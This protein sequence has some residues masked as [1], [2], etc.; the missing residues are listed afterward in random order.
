[1]AGSFLN[2]QYH[3]VRPARAEKLPDGRKR[4]TR[5]VSFK[6]NSEFPAEMGGTVAT[7]TDAASNWSSPPSGWSDLYLISAQTDTSLSPNGSGNNP[8]TILTYETAGTIAQTDETRNNG[9]LL[10]RTIRT[11]HTAPST[12]SGYTL[13]S[14]VDDN[15][16]WFDTFTY[17]FAKGTGQ[18]S[19]SDETKNNGALLLTTIR[20]ITVPGVL[21]TKGA[22]PISTPAGYTLVS[23]DYSEQDGH[24]VWV[25][26]YAKGVG[27]IG[28]TIDYRQ[29][30]DAG[31]TGATITTIRYIV[32]DEGTVMPTSLAGSVEI[33][34]DYV[35]QDGYR[36]WTTTWAKGT[37]LV[38]Q[39][40]TARQDGLREV[41]NVA[42]GT[43]S[44]PSGVVIR[45]DYSIS[46]GYKIYTVTSMQEADGGSTPTA[47]TLEFERY[48]PFTY[49]GRA[50]T[51][52]ETVNSATL[53]DVFLSPP[54]TTDVKATITI[55]YTTTDTIG[56]VSDYWNP[57]GWAT[58]RAVWV[59]WGEKPFN[60]VSALTGYRSVSDS[61]VEATASVFG[62]GSDLS[63]L[64]NPVFGGKKAKIWCTGGP[65]DP[66]G[67]TYTLDVTLE[68]A[69]TS[70]AGTKY[71]RKTVVTA[72]IPAQSALPV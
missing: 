24:R 67:N 72:T 63:C 46:G 6:Q 50:K 12:P 31:T 23:E 29:S 35:D 52:T 71:Y 15:P 3:E 68:P 2:S 17:T 10:I 20:Y 21:G 22:N 47:V 49:P 36:I 25:A 11:A 38:G 60:Q 13:I 41:T 64:G 48:V 69:F 34:R 30:D 45:D 27:E 18:V 54:V 14:T 56:T 51:F 66:G 37:G 5:F 40:I 42:L 53:L 32:A 62:S 4:L 57:T 58:L 8:V 9:A 44:A 70:T 61:A 26:T 1:M 39:S 7:S 19:Q 28:R 55:T 33:G 59:G 65:T 16:S 43:R